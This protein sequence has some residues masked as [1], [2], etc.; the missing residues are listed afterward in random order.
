MASELPCLQCGTGSRLS[1]SLYGKQSSETQENKRWIAAD[2]SMILT[3]PRT[4]LETY[5]CFISLMFSSFIYNE[6]GIVC[7][8][9]WIWEL[10]TITQ[11]LVF[12][13]HSC[14]PVSFTSVPIVL[15]RCLL[16]S[17]HSILISWILREQTGQPVLNSLSG[18]STCVCLLLLLLFVFYLQ[19]NSIKTS[20]YSWFNF[21]PINLFEQF[22]RLANAYFLILL[23]LQVWPAKTFSR[24]FLSSL[25][26]GCIISTWT[27]R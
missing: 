2:L 21:L 7:R 16:Y 1:L 22:Q 11:T 20:K 18:S 12:F 3:V 23:F 8:I 4:H 10:N 27:G 24:V 26:S 13:L 17:L 25:G 6:Y 19:D 5:R 14:Y 15:A 9:W